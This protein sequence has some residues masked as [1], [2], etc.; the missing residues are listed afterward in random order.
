MHNCLQDYGLCIT[1]TLFFLSIFSVILRNYF[2]EAHFLQIQ[3]ICILY[4]WVATREAFAKA[5]V[6]K[7]LQTFQLSF[8][9]LIISFDWHEKILKIDAKSFFLRGEANENKQEVPKMNEQNSKHTFQ[10]V[11]NFSFPKCAPDINDYCSAKDR[12]QYAIYH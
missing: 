9:I 10:V 5:L 8:M 2:Y 11:V 7:L 4:F 12:H 3:L 6:S 1:W